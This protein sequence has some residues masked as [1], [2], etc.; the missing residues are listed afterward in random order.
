MSSLCFN[1]TQKLISSHSLMINAF[2]NA[3]IEETYEQNNM[4]MN[5]LNIDIKYYLEY[6]KFKMKI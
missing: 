2:I 6:K 5:R 3:D 4:I 1:I